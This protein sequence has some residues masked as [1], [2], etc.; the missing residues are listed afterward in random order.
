MKA[1]VRKASL[2]GN[3]A[4]SASMEGGKAVPA[5]GSPVSVKKAS[6]STPKGGCDQFGN[7]TRKGSK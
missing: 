1:N 3:S 6:L 2:S 5:V 7:P 4:S